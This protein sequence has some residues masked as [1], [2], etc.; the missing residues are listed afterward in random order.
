MTPQ[1]WVEEFEI[2]IQVY[3]PE[4]KSK[5]CFHPIKMGSHQP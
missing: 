4:S 3:L 2:Q 5:Y 1:L